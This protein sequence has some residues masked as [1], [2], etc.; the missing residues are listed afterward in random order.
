MIFSFALAVDEK[1]NKNDAYKNVTLCYADTLNWP[2]TREV[3]RR[4]KEFEEIAHVHFKAY[5]VGVTSS[6]EEFLKE[7]NHYGQK[8]FQCLHVGG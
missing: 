3:P 4:A 2:F 7:F 5:C 1:M 6:C 8:Y